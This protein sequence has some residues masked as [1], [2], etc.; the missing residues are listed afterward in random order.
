MSLCH[1]LI[2]D[3]LLMISI[4]AHYSGVFIFRTIF[5][6]LITFSFVQITK[7]WSETKMA[8]WFYA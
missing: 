5:A 2:E 7:N 6:L 1:S 8:K 3:S 4:G